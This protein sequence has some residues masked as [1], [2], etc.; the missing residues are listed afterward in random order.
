[1][2]SHP[3]QSMLDE[4]DHAIR[5]FVPTLPKEVT[6]EAEAMLA[7]LSANVEADEFAIKRAFHDMGIKEYPHRKAYKEL[8]DSTAGMQM[9]AMVVEHVDEDVRAVIKPH[10]DSGVSLEELV[11]S[12]VFESELD[13]KQRYQVEDGIM[14]AQS[15]L[16]DGL[17]SEVSEHAAE[18]KALF[19]K[20]SAHA[21]EIDATIANLEKLSAGGDENQSAEIKGKAQRYREGFLVTEPDPDLAEIKKEIEYWTDTFAE[22]E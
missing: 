12:D 7:E 17:K 3:H 1:M 4:F 13:G 14:V 20:W 22:E 19:E 9:K 15:K 5:H 6:T 21:Q 8:T 10:L 2:S 11:R 16:A 18:Y